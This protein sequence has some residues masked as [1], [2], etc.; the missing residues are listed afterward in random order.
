VTINCKYPRQFS[1]WL[2]ELSG[3]ILSDALN[4]E[5]HS[6]FALSPCDEWDFFTNK[7]QKTWKLSNSQCSL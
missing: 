1:L 2:I 7:Q 6:E 4:Q 5:T 3:V